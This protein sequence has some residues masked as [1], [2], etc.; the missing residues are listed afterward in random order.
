MDESALQRR[1]SA[2]ERRQSLILS[3]N[4]LAY[5]LGGGWLLVDSVDAITVW[6]AGIALTVVAVGILGGGVYR[7]RRRRS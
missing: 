4:V 7:R 1:L 3:L 6:H 2:I 5:A